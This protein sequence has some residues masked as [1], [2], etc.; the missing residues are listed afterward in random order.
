MILV[1]EG[2]L[3]LSDPVAKHLPAFKDHRNLLRQL[4]YQAVAD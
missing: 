1:E 3:Q 2:K 4:V